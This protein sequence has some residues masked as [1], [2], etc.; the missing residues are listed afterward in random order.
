MCLTERN[1]IEK[2]DKYLDMFVTC[3][4]SVVSCLTDK[5]SVTDTG[6]MRLVD[7]SMLLRLRLLMQIFPF[8]FFYYGLIVG[9]RLTCS[10]QAVEGCTC[11]LSSQL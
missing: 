1:I 11:T 5:V 8:D 6:V 3:S 4:Q 9:G 7:V 2:L 10:C